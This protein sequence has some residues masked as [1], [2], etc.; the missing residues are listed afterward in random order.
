MFGG[1]KNM[2]SITFKKFIKL[3]NLIKIDFMKIDCEGGE[4]HVFTDENFDYIKQ[5]VKK[6]SGEWH[7]KPRKKKLILEISGI[8]Y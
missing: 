1:E 8:I 2:E 3:Y 4:Y 5:N 6:I 7:L